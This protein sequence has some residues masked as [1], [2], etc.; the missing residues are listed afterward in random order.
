RLQRIESAPGFA[1]HAD[2]AVAPRL[3]AEPIDHLAG[4]LQPARE[5]FIPHVPVGLARATHV[6][7]DRSITLPREPAMHGFVAPPRPVALAIGYIFE[8]RGD[9]LVSRVLGQ[10]KTRG[11]ASAV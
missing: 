3:S 2:A 8:D 7:A 5:K 11:E 4:V 1:H 9:R 10:P 6:D